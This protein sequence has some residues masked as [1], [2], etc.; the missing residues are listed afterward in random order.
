[1]LH[2]RLARAEDARAVAEIQCLG[3]KAAYQGI[4]DDAL[5]EKLSIERRTPVWE[6]Q[7]VSPPYTHLV[8]SQGASGPVQGFAGFG[9]SRDDDLPPHVAELLAMY[10][11]PESWG[12]GYGRALWNQ[13]AELLAGADFRQVSLWVLRDNAPARRFYER[14]GCRPD[15][16]Q[17][18][19][20]SIQATECRYLADCEKSPP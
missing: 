1:M 20:P 7:L 4:L 17:R 13:M 2:V 16:A 15:G 11:L 19:Q 18:M 12:Q 14:M 10:V 5:L 9:P 3:W 8:A 6:K